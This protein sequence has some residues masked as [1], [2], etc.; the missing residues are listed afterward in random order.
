MSAQPAVH[1]AIP[2]ASPG[3]GDRALA[4]QLGR[5]PARRRIVVETAAD[6][7]SSLDAAAR[8]GAAVGVIASCTVVP[9]EALL[10]LFDDPS[11][12]VGALV[13]QRQGEHPV[14][15]DGV[16]ILSAGTAIHPVPNSDAG[17]VG[18]L[19][20]C[21]ASAGALLAGAR[22]AVQAWPEAD[23]VDL[24][25]AAAVRTGPAPVSA[26]RLDPLPGGRAPDAAAA[27]RLHTDVASVDAAALASRNAARSGDGFYSTFALRRIAAHLTP[28]AVRRGVPANLVTAVSALIGLG[29]SAAFAL[30][31]YPAL[32]IGAVLLQLSLVLDCVDGE[33]A[34]T[35]RTR[36]PFGAWLDAATDRVKEYAALAGLAVAA[37]PGWWWVAAAGMVVQTA[38]HLQDFAFAKGALAAARRAT[39]RDRRPLGDTTAWVRP[40][41]AAPGESRTASM[42]LRRVIHMPIGERWLVLSV[43][44]VLDAPAAALDAYLALAALSGLW[45]MLGAIRRSTPAV[46][47]Y[48]GA[49]AATLVAYRDDGVPPLTRLRARGLLGWLLPSLVTL[50]EGA[51]VLGA[52]EAAAPHWAAAAFGWFAIVAWHR[53]DVIYRRGGDTPLVPTAISALGG[54]WLLR[55]V[56]VLLGAALGVLP[57]VL[58]AGAGWL[59]VVYLPESLRAGLRTATAGTNE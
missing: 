49:L 41:G 45:A 11:L 10:R 40:A 55:S 14:G 25:L 17:S 30:R 28:W 13:S 22:D 57:A 56:V 54:G 39:L 59:L 48:D 4:E 51:V 36:S 16:T 27:A 58:V 2:R 1:V 19:Y 52:T 33:I 37:G 24:A 50:L 34:R 44:A 18:V 35:T 26:V 15:T 8:D 53:Y 23:A 38:R 20:A 7:L 43:A 31:S 5:L 6:W 12:R 47:R 21:A 9:D 42:W 32:M 3:A 29:G 46:L